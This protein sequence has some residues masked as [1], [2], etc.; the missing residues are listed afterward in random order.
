MVQFFSTPQKKT[1]GEIG[2]P[3]TEERWAVLVKN[4]P[5]GM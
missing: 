4:W 3:E 1:M 2:M 5:V